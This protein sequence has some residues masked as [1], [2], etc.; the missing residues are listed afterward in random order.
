MTEL[1]VDAWR[2]AV[3]KRVAASYHSQAPGRR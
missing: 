3:P 1:V 2:M